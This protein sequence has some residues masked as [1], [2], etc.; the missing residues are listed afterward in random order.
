[1][2][3][4]SLAERINSEVNASVTYKTDMQQYGVPEMWRAARPGGLEDCDGYMLAKWGHLLAQRWPADK[5]VLT[6]CRTE[7]GE[8]H[9]VLL[10]DT[11]RGLFVLDNRHQ[12]PM[13][14]SKLP[15]TW[16]KGL[17][18]DQWHELSFA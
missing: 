9:A 6:E 7:L 18:V 5:L 3:N 10:A 11:D 14:P 13:I 4:Y 15:Y 12:S 2:N 16:I 17:K 1:M 8:G